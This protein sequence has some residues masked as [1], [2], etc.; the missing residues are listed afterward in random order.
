MSYETLVY[1]NTNPHEFNEYILTDQGYSLVRY[2]ADKQTNLMN[3]SDEPIPK[4]F[5]PNLILNFLDKDLLTVGK[6][7]TLKAYKNR[8]GNKAQCF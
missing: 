5:K 8:N 3:N 7:N 2:Q 6:R 1:P 4:L